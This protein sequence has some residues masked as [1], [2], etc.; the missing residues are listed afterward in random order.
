MRLRCEEVYRIDIVVRGSAI[1]NDLN[2]WAVSGLYDVPRARVQAHTRDILVQDLVLVDYVV[3]ELLGVCVQHQH[4]PLSIALLGL[5]WLA[6]WR[7]R[8]MTYIAASDLSYGG[9]YYCTAIST[10]IA[11]AQ[12]SFSLSRWASIMERAM[13]VLVGAAAVRTRGALRVASKL[14]AGGRSKETGM[15]E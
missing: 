8:F 12:R 6:A 13:V 7:G 1:S 14:L 2:V 5:G 15:M 9:Q 3:Y 11:A 10:C 4:F